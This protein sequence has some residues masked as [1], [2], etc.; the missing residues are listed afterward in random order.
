M[1]VEDD[2]GLRKMLESILALNGYD[3]YQAD[4][5]RQ[6]NQV[7]QKNFPKIDLLLTDVCIPYQ[8]TGIALAKT[9]LA[10]KPWLKVIYMS[11]FDSEIAGPDEL[12]LVEGQNFLHKPCSAEDLLLTI[13]K[14]FPDQ[15]QL[16]HNSHRDW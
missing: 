3:V 9:F 6:A 11:G 14:A 7:W 10:Q 15:P 4:C 8:T 12:A 5:E 2:E 1:I 13:K 16:A